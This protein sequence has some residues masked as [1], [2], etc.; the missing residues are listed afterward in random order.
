MHL[1]KNLPEERDK[2]MEKNRV[3]V[4]GLGFVGL[5]LA[6][7][8]AMKGHKVTGLDVN[9]ALAEDLNQGKTECLEQYHGRCAQ[10]ILLKA[11]EAGTFK[12]TASY[13]EAAEESNAYIVTV[14]LPVERQTPNLDFLESC[15]SDLGQVLDAGDLVLIRSTVVPGTT[16]EKVVPILERESGL[17]A[18]KDF[19]VGYA[20][21]RIAEGKAFD[22]FENMP[23]VV[24]GVNN[25]SAEK[26][27]ALLRLISKAE[28][29]I[30]SDIKVV[31]TAKVFEN[32]SRDVNIALA[33]QFAQFCQSLGIDTS[34]TFQIANTHTR[35]NL[36][37]P[38]PGVGG[39]CLPNAYYYLRPKH[40]EM[41]IDMPL[42]STARAI[43]D[44]VPQRLVGKL[45]EMLS[46]EGKYAS[47]AVAAGFGTG[48]EGLF[49]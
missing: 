43:N 36:L 16:E 21:E 2:A 40:M 45:V 22:E 26:S 5:P 28:I 47:G 15:A 31:E 42:L 19:F 37:T 38:G 30:A 23:T 9:E 17:T 8:F 24:S 39:Y 44:G 41:G 49:Q 1:Q 27:A 3:T 46:L 12:A 13:A 33:N 20:S 34:E 18:G 6:L 35:V 25:E 7:S 32:V 11:L 4:I 14:G 29:F 10:D 48:H